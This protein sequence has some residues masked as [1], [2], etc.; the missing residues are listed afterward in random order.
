[1]VVSIGGIVA[2]LVFLAPVVVVDVIID[3]IP[4]VIIIGGDI[5]W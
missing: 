5:K 3:A 2:V 1:M 4:L